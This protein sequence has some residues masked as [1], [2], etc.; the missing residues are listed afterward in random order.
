M[1]LLISPARSGFTL[2]VH[3]LRFE[4]VTSQSQVR[5]PI[6]YLK[7]MSGIVLEVK[8]GNKCR[9][10]CGYVNWDNV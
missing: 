9:I 6:G 3:W 8:E 4:P 1:L 2:V 7:K 10:D 5:Y